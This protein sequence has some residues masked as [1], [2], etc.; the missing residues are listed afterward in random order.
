MIT[1]QWNPSGVPLSINLFSDA[2][3]EQE[4][5][6]RQRFLITSRASVTERDHTHH[7]VIRVLSTTN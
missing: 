7:L 3:L 5:R 6:P 1:L 4:M 2:R